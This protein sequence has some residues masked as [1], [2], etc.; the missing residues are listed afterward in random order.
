MKAKAAEDKERR[1]RIKQG[2]ANP[3]DPLDVAEQ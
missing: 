3:R 1:Q 2:E